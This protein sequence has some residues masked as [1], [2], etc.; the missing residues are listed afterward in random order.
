MATL[1]AIGYPDETTALSAMDEAER[2]QHE[3]VIQADAIAAIVRN[4]EGKIRVVTNHHAV[5]AGATWG[6]FWGMLFGMLFFVPFLGMAVGAGMGAL[7]GKVTKSA[8]DKQ[9][10]DQVRDMLQP[11]TS[12]LFMVVEKVTPDKAVEAMSKYGGT[13][14]K[15]SLSNEAERELQEALHG[16][17]AGKETTDQ[18]RRGWGPPGGWP[19][20]LTSTGRGC[21]LG[22][23]ARLP[24]APPRPGSSR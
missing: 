14:L 13:V 21:A 23:P 10:Q 9:F 2:L 18:E 3:L 20:P 4:K 6:M 19:P 24:V 16:E 7:M 1:V 8:V 17:G 11:G 15:S 22:S 12:A 5:G